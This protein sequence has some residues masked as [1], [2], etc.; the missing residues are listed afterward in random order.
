MARYVAADLH[1]SHE[2]IIEYC[3]RPFETVEEMN[4]TLISNWNNAVDDD[5]VV[6]FLGDLAFEGHKKSVELYEQL[7]GN[8]L[9]TP[10]NHDDQLNFETAP[11]VSAES[12]VIQYKKYRFYC[13]HRPDNVPTEWT[14]WVIYGHHHNNNLTKY[15]F[16]DY[17][18]NRIN[19]S[20]ELTDYKPLKLEKLYEYLEHKT[21]IQT[22]T[23]CE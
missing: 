1:L 14:E 23:S 13:T 19:A 21:T 3:D 10:G 16:V 22:I 11:I 6:Y 17:D 12:F 18:N 8:K 2:N 20:M 7:N 15:P 4:E 5:D 9:M